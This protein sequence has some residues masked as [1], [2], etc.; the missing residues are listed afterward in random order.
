MPHALRSPDLVLAI[1]AYQAGYNQHTMAIVRALR[2]VSMQ[3]TQRLPKILGPFHVRFAV[4][5][6]RFGVRGLDQ[7]VTAGYHEHLLYYALT[8]SNTALLV[9]LDHRLSDAHWAVAATYAHLSVFQHLFAT[10]EAASCPALVMRTAASTGNMPLL[11]FLHQ[12]GAPVAHDT[13]KAACN[14]GHT[15]VAEYCLAHGLGVW[16]R[17][18]VA[19][20]VLHGRT[21][22]VQFLH[23]HRYPGFSAETMDLA[24]AYGRLDIVT[25]LHKSRQ[26]GCTAR[27]MIEAAANGHV[28][29]VRFLDT[30]RREGNALAALAAALRHGRVLVAKYFLF[31]RRVGLDKAKVTALANQCHH[32]A[33]TT[34]LAAL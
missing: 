6:L 24:A 1:V 22:V 30:F 13:L 29:V 11:R 12:H 15:K 14:G 17:S 8:Y 25:F 7:L 21:N 18:T 34:L 19:I 4:W 5:H 2:G 31:E 10:G 3:Q 33:L 28:Y 26:E 16:D 20:A 32:P 9:H 23:R 27:A